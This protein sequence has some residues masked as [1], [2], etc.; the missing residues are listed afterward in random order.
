MSSRLAD[1]SE[2]S[3]KK[4]ARTPGFVELVAPYAAAGAECVI[5]ST[6]IEDRLSKLQPLKL[7]QV[8]HTTQEPPLNILMEPHR[9]LG[10]EQ[11]VGKHLK[12]MVWT[13]N[14]P[15]AF[16]AADVQ[17]CF[18]LDCS[19]ARLRAT[20]VFTVCRSASAAFSDCSWFFSMTAMR[21]RLTACL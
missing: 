4:K 8:R 2:V 19:S 1:I 21:S 16:L 14:R 17:G 10:D 11:P 9:Y 3:E 6:P 7:E 18:A 5:D 20:S 13:Q 15:V 12:Y